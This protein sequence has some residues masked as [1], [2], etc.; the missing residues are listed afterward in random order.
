ML[1]PTPKKTDIKESFSFSDEIK[2]SAAY[3]VCPDVLNTVFPD[4]AAEGNLVVAL[5]EET[6]LAD[7]SDE[8][9]RTVCVKKDG[10]LSVTVFSASEKGFMRGAL[11]LKRM[12]LK[13]EFFIGEI[14]DYPDFAVRGYIEGFYGKPWK[15]EERLEMLSLMALF[16]ENTH[17]YAP[18]D[19]PYH[20]SKWRELYPEEEAENLKALVERAKSYKMDFHYCIAPGLSMCYSDEKDFLCLC[21]KTKQLFS[22]GIE[23]FGLLLDDIPADL[24]YENDKRLFGT[25]SKAH[26]ELTNR[27]YAFLKELSQDCMLT[28]CPSSYRGKGTEKELTDF[29]LNIH[30]NVRVFFTGSDICSKE[31][32]RDEAE[33]F[34]AHNNHKPL[35]W[36]N[37]PVND[38]EMFMEMHIGPVIGRECDLYESCDGIISNCMEYFNCNKIPLIT[39]A[40]YLWNAG[41]YE[42]ET[43]YSEA[44][45]FLFKDDEEK[46][47]FVL[48]ADHFRTSCLHDENSRL[49]GERLSEASVRMWTGDSAGALQLLEKLI[50]RINEAARRLEMRDGCIYR[51]LHRWIKKFVLMS[52]ILTL[53]LNVLKGEDERALLESKMEQYNE[54]ATV[55]TSFCFREYIEG[56][57]SND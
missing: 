31:I 35:Y 22:M 47:D 54:S 46:E 37:Y 23:N 4:A 19:D 15:S 27:Y 42:P 8:A 48:L 53:S 32:T 26:A 50:K 38:A 51:E 49:L 21:E 33:R 5:R 39:V 3:E 14:V 6:S 11:S 20:R 34:A 9:F 13:N 36:D 44:L 28:V 18:K 1:F 41:A 40:A 10:I 7:I 29:T 45:D 56:V 30:D 2:I 55:L 24:F 43:A 52:D 17:Y 16:G 12:C 25:S 57:L